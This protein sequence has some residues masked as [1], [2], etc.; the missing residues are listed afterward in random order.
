MACGGGIVKVADG[1]RVGCVVTVGGVC[2]RWRGVP[3]AKH[4]LHRGEAL[5]VIRQAGR[6]GELEVEADSTVL[7]ASREMVQL[8]DAA[9]SHQL[10]KG[11]R[12]GRCER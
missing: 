6:G 11:G 10:R 3:V 2:K 8:L 5:L 1:V 4:E 12:D 9:V 7:C